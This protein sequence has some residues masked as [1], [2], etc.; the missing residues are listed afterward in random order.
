MQAE[1]TFSVNTARR[2]KAAE[3]PIFLIT[4]PIRRLRQLIEGYDWSKC[5]KKFEKNI[6]WFSWAFIIVSVIY[7]IPVCLNIFI[8]ETF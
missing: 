1:A 7:L 6:N 2:T 5:F 8:R 4:K 3:F